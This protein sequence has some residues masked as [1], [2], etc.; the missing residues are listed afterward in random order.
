MW[1]RD[2]AFQI[3]VLMPRI[4][5]RP[6]LRRVVE[7]AIRAQAFYIAQDPY[8]N[9]F[10]PEWRHPW[11]HNPSDR[12]LG[13]GGWV[14]VRN[15][16]LDS[17][18]RLAAGCRL[19]GAMRVCA[20]ARRALLALR[21]HPLPPPPPPPHPHTHHPNPCRAGAYYLNLLWNYYRTPGLHRPEALLADP[22]IFD[23]AATMVRL[24]V[25]EQRHNASSPYR[26][27]ELK[28]NG[29][30]PPVGYTGARRCR[31]RRRPHSRAAARLLTPAAALPRLPPAAR[32]HDL[33]R[34]P[35]LGR[36]QHLRLLGAQQHVRRGRA[37]ARAGAQPR[38]LAQRRVWRHRLAAAG[39][40]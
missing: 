20:A 1:L 36:P 11:D 5:R 28:N 37:A 8:A 10:Y 17:G 32:R 27:T 35:P 31:R 29:L 34:L 38:H 13:R 23:A 33:V 26:F 30:G 19:S 6:S 24:W 18:E 39:R 40:H 15:Y 14:G 21:P 2:S 3:G 4:R 7:G 25:A 16:E 22:L 12:R 9:G